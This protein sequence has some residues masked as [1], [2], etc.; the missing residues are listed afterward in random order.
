MGR[1]AACLRMSLARYCDACTFTYTSPVPSRL[2]RESRVLG[3]CPAM[4][5]MSVAVKLPVSTP[6]VPTLGVRMQSTLMPRLAFRPADAWM[7]RPVG[8]LAMRW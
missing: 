7:C 3:G 5:R 4:R 2:V 1:R 8:L 6:F